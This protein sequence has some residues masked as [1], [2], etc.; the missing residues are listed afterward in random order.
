LSFVINV[1]TIAGMYVV[2]YNCVHLKGGV[3]PFAQ[4]NPSAW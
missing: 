1:V 3:L 2:G 4:T